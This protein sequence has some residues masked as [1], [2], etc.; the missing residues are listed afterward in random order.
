ML[1]RKRGRPPLTDSDKKKNTAVY[2]DVQ[3]VSALRK[4]ADEIEKLVGFRPTFSQ[5]IS[6][7]VMGNNKS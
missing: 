7:L 3:A 6:N 4:R 2:L 5:I 1:K